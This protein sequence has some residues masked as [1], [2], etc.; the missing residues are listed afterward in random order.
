MVINLLI[1]FYC[2]YTEIKLNLIFNCI[3][4]LCSTVLQYSLVVPIYIFLD[5]L[6]DLLWRQLYHLQI[7]TLF[8]SFPIYMFSFCFLALLLWLRL[9]VWQWIGVVTT[10]IFAFLY[11]GV[12]HSTFYPYA[13]CKMQSFFFS[14]WCFTSCWRCSLLFLFCQESYHECALNLSNVYLQLLQ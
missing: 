5:I 9:L 13:K 4:I 10:N 12:K 8:S 3:L 7:D 6:G 1:S 2:K 11:T 14:C